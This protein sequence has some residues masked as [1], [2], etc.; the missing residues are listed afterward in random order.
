MSDQ[1][2]TIAILVR[3]QSAIFALGAAHDEATKL[4]DEPLVADL[5]HA[6]HAVCDIFDRLNKGIGL[7]LIGAG[8][9]TVKES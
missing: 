1:D 8:S 7:Q 2:I 9:V 4:D 5:H 6:H 3:L